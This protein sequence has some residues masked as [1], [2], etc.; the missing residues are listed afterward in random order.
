MGKK[1]FADLICILDKYNIHMGAEDYK[2]LCNVDLNDDEYVEI[3]VVRIE[4]DMI[5]TWELSGRKDK[6][7][8]YFRRF[9]EGR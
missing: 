8:R 3:S 2:S 1:A 4:A 7:A 6:I 9:T 5:A